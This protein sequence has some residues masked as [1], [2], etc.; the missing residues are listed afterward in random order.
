M[1]DTKWY[2][3]LLISL[4]LVF[5]IRSILLL[6]ELMQKVSEVPIGFLHFRIGEHKL[7]KRHLGGGGCS[8][9]NA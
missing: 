8:S 5:W 7:E 9:G 2:N 4:Y 3:N 1:K 6:F